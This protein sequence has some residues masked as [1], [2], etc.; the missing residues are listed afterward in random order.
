M[1]GLY[2][3]VGIFK[4]RPIG[5]S[6]KYMELSMA[7]ILLAI[8]LPFFLSGT[9]V[10][11]NL[12]P[13]WFVLPRTE[14]AFVNSAIILCRLTNTSVA[15][16]GGWIP[17]A[18][19]FMTSI[20]QLQMITQVGACLR[21]WVDHKAGSLRK[22]EGNNEQN[23]LIKSASFNEVLLVHRQ[24]RIILL[25]ANETHYFS[26]PILLFFGQSI[27]VLSSY[28]TIKMHDIIPMPFYL[29][30]PCL[31]V[32]VVLI[33]MSLFPS[34]SNIYEESDRFL[35]LV[36][37]IYMRDKYWRKAWRSQPAIRME[38]GPLFFAKK[39]TK[40]TFLASCVDC[41]FDALLTY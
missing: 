19:Y 14:N 34:A 32:Y 23:L 6:S 40:T 31:S 4:E 17:L 5:Q 7:V 28:A 21:V 22:R 3:H 33:I 29:G 36:R 39:S 38:F 1:N 18:T 13:V 37:G 2:I 41:I 27:L 8:V 20:L 12:D 24:A 11:L 16:Y 25:L 15:T 35:N 30:M 9:L 26:L 10:L